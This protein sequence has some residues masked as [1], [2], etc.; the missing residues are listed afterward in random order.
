MSTTD[1][2]L[3]AHLVMPQGGG[4]DQLLHDGAD[5]LKRRF[6]IGHATLQ[7]ECSAGAC[8]LEPDSVI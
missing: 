2:A 3:T 4:N 7:V 5:A 8:G 6:G 1:V